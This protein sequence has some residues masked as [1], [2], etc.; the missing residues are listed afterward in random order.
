MKKT[1]IMSLITSVAATAILAAASIPLGAGAVWKQVDRMGD[2]NLDGAVNVADLVTLSKH[3]HGKE[4]LSSKSLYNIGYSYYEID[5]TDDMSTF[6]GT[7]IKNGRGN[8]QKA[9]I[10]QD[11]VIDVFDFVELRKSVISPNAKGNIYR[12][13]QETTT[14]ICIVFFQVKIL[15]L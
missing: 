10:N 9:D 14:T 4:K 6:S 7:K 13:Y 1:T 11:G 8:I 2:L 3:L 15:P 5:R 12:W